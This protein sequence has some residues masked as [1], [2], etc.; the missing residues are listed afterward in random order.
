MT[1]KREKTPYRVAIT[2]VG[3]GVGQ[4]VLRA[5]RLSSLPLR[6]IG[7]DVNLWSAGLYTCSKG[8]A[9]PHSSDPSFVDQLLENLLKEKVKVLIPG[10]DPEVMIISRARE[11]FMASGIFPVTGSAKAVHLCRDKLAG[12]KFFKEHNIPFARTVSASEAADLADEVGFPLIVKPVGGSASRGIAI[13]FNKE[14]LDEHLQEGN[15]IVQEY[16]IPERWRKKRPELTRQDVYEGF[17]ILQTDE[18]SIQIV[19]DHQGNLVGKFTSCNV[20][21]DGVPMLIDPMAIPQA[22]AIALKMASLLAER[23]MV[24]PCNLQC[25]MTELGPVFFEMNP[26]FTGITAVRAAMGFNEVE[27]ILRRVLLNEPL[28]EVKKRLKVPDNLVCSRYITEAV[29]PRQDLET[30]KKQGMVEGHANKTTL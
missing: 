30:L 8:Y 22:E 3:G 10:S 23:G 25:K 21:R 14:Q 12:Y 19:Y 13:A 26:R 15:K 27:A 20:L 7:F 11:R 29:I 4:S 2:A 16:L 18:I 9:I 17:V 1:G 28:D 6:T 5:L 24:G